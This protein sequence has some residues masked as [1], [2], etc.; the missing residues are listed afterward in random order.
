MGKTNEI[1]TTFKLALSSQNFNDGHFELVAAYGI[2]VLSLIKDIFIWTCESLCLDCAILLCLPG[3]VASISTLYYNI[4]TDRYNGGNNNS[5]N[6][7][8]IY[9]YSIV[10]NCMLLFTNLQLIT[11]LDL[12]IDLNQYQIFWE[13]NINSLVI[14]VY[15]S[16]LHDECHI[17]S[18]RNLSFQNTWSCYQV[19]VC[20]LLFFLSYFFILQ[21]WDPI[22]I[23]LSRHLSLK[24]M[25]QVGN[26]RSCICDHMCISGISFWTFLQFFYWIL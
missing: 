20:L 7:K 16:R 11:G 4:S 3:C 23:S 8:I 21:F 2:Y 25:L 24:C 14:S 15:L 17:L 1:N 12:I 22:P 26:E 9:L 19:E 18:R 5:I 10:L 13:F 6:I